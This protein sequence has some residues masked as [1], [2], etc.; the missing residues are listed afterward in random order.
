MTNPHLVVSFLSSLTHLVPCVHSYLSPP[1]LSVVI[2][3]ISVGCFPV[4]GCS[5]SGAE[6]RALCHATISKRLFICHVATSSGV[7]MPEY[8][9]E[10]MHNAHSGNRWRC[11][12]GEGGAVGPLPGLVDS[13]AWGAV[14]GQFLL[15]SY[16]LFFPYSPE[17]VEGKFSEVPH[18]PGPSAPGLSNRPFFLL[19]TCG[20]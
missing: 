10:Y 12:G 18:R 17:C 15:S 11:G 20:S 16:D 4:R 13:G 1:C 7:R 14:V 5:L 2:S 8:A 19:P 9:E 3:I 6:G